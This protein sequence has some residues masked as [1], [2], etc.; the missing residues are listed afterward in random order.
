VKT[1]SQKVKSTY[2]LLGFEP[3]VNSDSRGSGAVLEGKDGV[4]D[5]GNGGH[6]VERGDETVE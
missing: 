5:G 6:D 1:S 3:F 2:F 4:F